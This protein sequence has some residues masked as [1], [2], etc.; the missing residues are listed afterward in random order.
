MRACAAS[1]ARAIVEFR[2]S[3]VQNAV[4]ANYGAQS[5]ACDFNSHLAAAR[6]KSRILTNRDGA[7][8][9][10]RANEDRTGRFVNDLDEDAAHA[11]SRPGNHEPHVRHK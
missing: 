9:F 5:V 10:D 1:G 8:T 2:R 7:L 3:E 11:S 6:Q 4:G